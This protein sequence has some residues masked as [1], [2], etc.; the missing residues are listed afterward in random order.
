[1]TFSCSRSLALFF[2]CVSGGEAVK[3]LPN[4]RVRE[5]DF[6]R[7][8]SSPFLQS[9]VSF[10]RFLSRVT[11]RQRVQRASMERERL[12]GVRLTF[13][14]VVDW[15]K[16]KRKK[17]RNRHRG[18]AGAPFSLLSLWFWQHSRGIYSGQIF[19][20]PYATVDDRLRRQRRAVLDPDWMKLNSL[21][22]DLYDAHAISHMT[23]DF[24]GSGST[25]LVTWHV[26]HS[27]F[28]KYNPGIWFAST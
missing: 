19:N 22:S 7:F 18:R 27:L 28:P 25:P 23:R 2:T 20:K 15:M 8:R 9:V 10:F 26:C 6:S 16:E 21:K 11:F 13:A 4:Y 3:P 5:S 24:H 14:K 17:K 12:C 1:V